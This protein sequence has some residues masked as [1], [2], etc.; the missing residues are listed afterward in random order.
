AHR[1]RPCY[2]T[3][4][5]SDLKCRIGEEEWVRLTQ[6]DP[7]VHPHMWEVKMDLSRIPAGRHSIEV[8]VSSPTLAEASQCIT[9]L[10]GPWS[11]AMRSEEHTSELQSRENLV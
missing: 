8:V 9:I 1:A 6:V 5:S 3:R 10:S 2:P 11:E 7:K 4:R